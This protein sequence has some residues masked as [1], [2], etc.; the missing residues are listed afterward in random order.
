MRFTIDEK[1]NKIEVFIS[2]EK[3]FEGLQI[4]TLSLSYENPT[5]RDLLLLTLKFIE[6][7]EKLIGR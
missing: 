4:S 2:Y 1:K 5:K 6:D 7:Y 3:P